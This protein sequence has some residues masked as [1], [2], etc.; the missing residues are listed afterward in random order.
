MSQHLESL[1]TGDTIDVRGPSGRI[2]YKG[3]G[4]FEIAVDK[5][6]PP[7]VRKVK[8]VG[9]IAGGTGIAPMYQLIKEIC[10]HPEDQTK[11]QLLFANQV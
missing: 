11:M 6:T 1:K 2:T 4:V 5:K 10:K 8:R 9:M 7:T 3:N